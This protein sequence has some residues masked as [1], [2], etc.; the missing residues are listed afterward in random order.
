[1]FV[2]IISRRAHTHIVFQPKDREKGICIGIFPFVRVKAGIIVMVGTTDIF[3]LSKIR[4]GED[5][6]LVGCFV[7]F[8]T[9]E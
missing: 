4:Y 2:Y 6:K 5:C 3:I 9:I 8:I 1:M 7:K